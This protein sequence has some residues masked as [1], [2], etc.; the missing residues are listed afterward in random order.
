P[1]RR[2]RRALLVVCVHGS[3]GWASDWDAVVPALQTQFRELCGSGHLRNDKHDIDDD[4]HDDDNDDVL[5]VMRSAVSEGARTVD[6]IELLAA[7]LASEVAEWAS[8]TVVPHL[9]LRLASNAGG[10]DASGDDGFDIYFSI[11]GHSLGG[12][13]ARAALP[14]LVGDAGAVGLRGTADAGGGFTVP[15]SLAA[16][17]DAAG[18]GPQRVVASVTFLS[19][20]SISTPH[21]G[22]RR[23]TTGEAAHSHAS[24]T[25][26]TKDRGVTVD[27]TA[28]AEGAATSSSSSP[29]A[30][31]TRALLARAL[32]F[33]ASHGIGRSGR[34]MMLLDS[35]GGSGSSS[36]GASD[37]GDSGADGSGPR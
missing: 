11:A 3:Y 10:G 25:A 18:G 14:F 17:L 15:P 36:D 24:A 6:G 32:D 30:T 13:I 29:T 31:W 34:E 26:M 8:G 28:A 7:R 27:G 37:S 21:L 4:Q 2:R 19:Y 20:L 12:L 1:R 22:V 9:Q 23:V 35:G 16:A 5:C 33:A